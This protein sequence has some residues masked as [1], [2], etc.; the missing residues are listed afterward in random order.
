MNY[1]ETLYFVAKCLTISLED[2]N[3][4]SIKK[5]L[6]SNNID[7]DSVVKV[8]TAH[9]V[10]PALYCNLKRANFLK[11]LPADLVEY[12]KFITN[13]NK[14]RNTKIIT[15]VNELNKILLDNKIT[16]IFLKGAGN[17]IAGLY[18]DIAERMVGDIDFLCSKGEYQKTIKF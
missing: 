9:Y 4:K 11:Y 13:L 1:K 10:F 18:E 16:P 3:K 6:Q 17:L 15:Q 5:Q 8:S 14:E 2:R 12:M 7:W